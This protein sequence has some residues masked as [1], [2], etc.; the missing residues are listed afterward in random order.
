[1]ATVTSRATQPAN[2]KGRASDT[3]PFPSSYQN[4]GTDIDSIAAIRRQRLAPLGLS[5][6]RA[7]LVASLAW[8]AVQ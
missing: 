3:R 4:F 1:M 5:K 8:G 7:D 2:R 6:M